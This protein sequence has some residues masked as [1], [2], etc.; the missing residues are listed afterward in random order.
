MYRTENQIVFLCAVIGFFSWGA[1]F[2]QGYQGRPNIVLLYADDMGY[3]DLGVQNSESKIPT[4]HLDRLAREGTRFTDA[5]S[6]SGICTPSRYALLQG[7]Y[8]WRK[9]HGI[10]NSFEGSVLDSSRWTLAE[11]VKTKGYQTACIGKWHLGWDWKAIQRP[12]AKADP[13]TGYAPDAFDWSLP[14]PDGPLAHG[15]DYYFGDDVP[16]F[17]PYAWIENDRVQRAPDVPLSTPKPTAEGAWEA[18]PGPSVKDWD[19]WAVMPTL[20]QRAVDWISEQ[21]PERPFFLYVPFTSPHAPIVPDR[22]FEG[23]SGADGY[24]D[25][26]VQTDASVGRILAALESKGFSE[27]TWVIF[28]SDNGPETYAYARLKNYGHRSMG[29][30]RGV[31]RDLYE[32]GHRVPMLMR[33]PGKIP[34][35]RVCDG[36]MSQIDLFATIAGVLAI[37]IPEGNAEDSLDQGRMVFGTGESSRETLVHN[38]NPK[39]YAIRQGAWL[40]IESDSGSISKVPEWFDR[41]NGYRQDQ[42]PGELYRLDVDLGQRENLYGLHADLNGDLQGG[43]VHAMHQELERIR[44]AKR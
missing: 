36:L 38:T 11:L 41:E 20:T 26:M 1:A 39:G 22:A 27:N 17:P 37:E 14:I 35:D 21:S 16:N 44:K 30:L 7:R 43:K 34:S 9:F 3:G 4:P 24:G 2:S 33:W 42:M 40:L 18:R 19:F 10:V 5:H 6:S 23:R 28:S 8:H 32:G 13:K 25:F 12:G 29:P 31:K 15:F